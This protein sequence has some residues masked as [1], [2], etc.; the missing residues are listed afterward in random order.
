MEIAYF[1]AAELSRAITI[2][3][4]VRRILDTFATRPETPLRQRIDASGGRELLVMPAILDGYAGVKTLTV[5]PANAG[6]ARQVISGL[7]TL[8]DFATGAPLAT[9]DSGELTAL[10]TATVSAAAASRLSRA[11]ATRL[12]VVG[13][14]HLAPYLA[15]GHASVRPIREVMFWA[16]RTAQAREAGERLRAMRPDLQITVSDGLEPAIR[17]ADIVTAA[18]RSTT[19]L[20]LGAWLRDGMHLDLVGGY[21]PDMREIDDAAA[22]R[23]ELFVDSRVAA[24][25][26]AGD[27]IGPIDAGAI[28]AADLRGDLADIAAGSAGRSSD[29]AIT[30]FKSVGSATADLV[31]AIAVFEGSKGGRHDG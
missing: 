21:R 24:L 6:T 30:T 7:F 23:S 19:P 5:I 17:R 26:E 28:D 31:T 13:A 8:F 20:I 2:P 15:A 16:R 27:I 11:D 10:R 25:S 9:F 3:D 29:R 22:A 12:T 18:T 4:L 14:G 1:T